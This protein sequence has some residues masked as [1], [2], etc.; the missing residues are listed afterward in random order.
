MTSVSDPW[1]VFRKVRRQARMR[2]FCFPYAGGGASAYRAW[3]DDL[4]QE[5]EVCP[6][7]LPGRESRLRETPFT[8]IAPLINALAQAL[9]PYLDLPFAL[10]GHSMGAVIS[11]ETAHR[12]Q[13]ERGLHPVQLLVSAR[14]APQV[15]PT[16]EPFHRLPDAEFR[17]KL[18]NLNGT[19]KSILEDAELMRLLL[20]LLRADFELND[21]YVPSASFMLECP[22]T[23]YGGLA[24]ALARRQH[25]EAWREVTHASFLLRIFP[26]GHFFFLQESRQSF[27]RAIAEDLLRFL[28]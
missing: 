7:Q 20:P 16:E 11:Y 5:V 15:P 19:P 25:L 3:G 17:Q 2:L 8:G 21:T 24:D 27:I 10:F 13:Q 12:L 18:R 1:I 14:R 23:V 9:V 6:V 4:P 26:G 22:I 28:H